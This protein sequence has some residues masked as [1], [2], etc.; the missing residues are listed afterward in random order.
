MNPGTVALVPVGQLGGGLAEEL[1]HVSRVGLERPLGGR[2]HRRI[3]G[4]R[5]LDGPATHAS[6]AAPLSLSS[7]DHLV[8][9]RVQAGLIL[10][11]EGDGVA[12]TRRRRGGHHVDAVHVLIRGLAHNADEALSDLH[13]ILQW[14]KLDHR[15][16]GAVD[17]RHL[18]LRRCC[19]LDQW[20]RVPDTHWLTGQ[21]LILPAARTTVLGAGVVVAVACPTS[22]DARASRLE[23]SDSRR[24]RT[25]ARFLWCH[26]LRTPVDER[27]VQQ[28]AR[29]HPLGILADAVVVRRAPELPIRLP[30]RCA[31]VEAVGHSTVLLDP[32]VRKV[33]EGGEVNDE[34]QF[35]AH[36]PLPSAA[37]S[38]PA[39]VQKFGPHASGPP[40]RGQSPS[41]SP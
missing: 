12:Q 11:G 40:R 9:G 30:E 26:H 15:L 27:L 3:P 14:A 36:R 13:Q 17:V 4:V 29:W 1:E 23:R 6:R 25:L 24:P 18:I 32:G 8:A 2:V 20:G 39:S 41:R 5:G 7:S 34:L 38:G 28:W 10:D 22:E 31:T 35:I 33:S 19:E 37:A 21:V 16:Q